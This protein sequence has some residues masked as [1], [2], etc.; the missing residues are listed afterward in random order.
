MKREDGVK[1]LAEYLSMYADKGANPV[2]HYLDIAKLAMEGVEKM[3]MLPP[4]SNHYV[5]KTQPLNPH[6]VIIKRY[7]WEE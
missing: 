1:F 5:F 6:D 4:Y 2:S 7:S 3:G